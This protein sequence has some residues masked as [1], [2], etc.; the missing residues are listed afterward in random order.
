M[1]ETFNIW[2]Y[3]INLS[4]EK[5]SIA[6][7]VAFLIITTLIAYYKDK[8]N[9]EFHIEM[10][11]NLVEREA[12]CI[13]KLNRITIEKDSMMLRINHLIIDSAVTQ[14]TN[15]LQTISKMAK[16][17]KASE[18]NITNKANKIKNKQEEIL[19]EL[20]NEN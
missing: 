1:K 13:E 3:I 6:V 19:N 20:H 4:P 15:D 17:V 7:I 8:A 10:K 18:K 11:K 14:L 16:N 9:Q 5:R 12:K 2:K